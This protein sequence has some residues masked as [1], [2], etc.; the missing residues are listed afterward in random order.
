M[1][2]SGNQ[3]VAAGSTS[4]DSV[5]R[6]TKRK[7]KPPVNEVDIPVAGSS[8]G[9]IIVHVCVCMRASTRAHVRACVWVYLG[10]HVCVCVCVCVCVSVCVCVHV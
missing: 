1:G 10:A 7:K 5:A 4:E 3:C 6:V 8:S 9:R 2:Y